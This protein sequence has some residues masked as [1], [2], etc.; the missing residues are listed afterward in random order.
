M[1]TPLTIR[2]QQITMMCWI[3]SSKKCTL[4]GQDR[5]N[6]QA[7]LIKGRPGNRSKQRDMPNI[8]LK[9]NLR[10]WRSKIL[11]LN[12]KVNIQRRYRNI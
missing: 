5:A 1:E 10:K 2:R 3:P 4:P 12:S 6:S 9:K 8:F 11:M 7:Q